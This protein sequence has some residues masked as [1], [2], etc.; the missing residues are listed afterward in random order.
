MI[1]SLNL[2]SSRAATHHL[3]EMG[4][5]STEIKSAEILTKKYQKYLSF[6]FILVYDRKRNTQMRV[7]GSYLI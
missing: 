1:N 7:R 4:V 3:K 5:F 6:L 2:N